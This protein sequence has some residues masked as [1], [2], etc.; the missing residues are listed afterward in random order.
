LIELN[1]VLYELFFTLFTRPRSWAFPERDNRITRIVVMVLKSISFD[2]P[3]N[4][5][6]IRAEGKE[7]LFEL[8]KYRSELL[9][10]SGRNN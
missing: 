2:L 4:L 6:L 7:R 1:E 3:P 8:S 10:K 9:A 5:L